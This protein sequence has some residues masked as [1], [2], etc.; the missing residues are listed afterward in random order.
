MSFWNNLK[1]GL[2]L[3]IGVVLAPPARVSVLAGSISTFIRDAAHD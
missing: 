2:R 3:G 1:I